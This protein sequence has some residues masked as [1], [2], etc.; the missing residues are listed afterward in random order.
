MDED[1]F[2]RLIEQTQLP[3][4]EYTIER[5]LDFYT[6]VVSCLTDADLI[7]F[8]IFIEGFNLGLMVFVLELTQS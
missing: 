6:K 4:S 3:E 5:H 8:P 7:D 2:W 1:G